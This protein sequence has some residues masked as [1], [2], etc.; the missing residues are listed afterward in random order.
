MN[1]RTLLFALICI[2]QTHL[3]LLAITAQ[4][5]YIAQVQQHIEAQ[6]D[7]N[8]MVVFDIDNTI[9]K[10]AHAIGSDS[11]FGHYIQQGI[12]SGLPAEKALEVTVPLYLFIHQLIDL[13]P[14]EPET[15]ELIAMLQHNNIKVIALT[16]RS[17]PLMKRTI[18]QLAKINIDFSPAN[19]FASNDILIGL[20]S[21]WTYNDG[22]I[23]CGSHTKGV[24]LLEFLNRLDEA[25]LPDTI[26]FIDDKEHHVCSVEKIVT[27]AGLDCVSIHYT[28]MEETVKNFN[29]AIADAQLGLLIAQHR[30]PTE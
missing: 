7:R 17:R 22:I 2:I 6:K 26:I 20:D 16:A 18:Q 25:Q 9:A 23:F 14:V 4:C 13:V 24:V 27:D 11:W 8:I 29:P 5:A 1:Y 30:I 10:S 28:F 19:T 3:S 15:I 21:P 12:K